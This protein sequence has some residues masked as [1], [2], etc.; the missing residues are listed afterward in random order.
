MSYH[1]ILVDLQ[2][3]KSVILVC[4]LGEFSTL[5]ITT[6]RYLL[7]FTKYFSYIIQAEVAELI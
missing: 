4:K 3:F 5:I 7:L 6:L 1:R 2:T